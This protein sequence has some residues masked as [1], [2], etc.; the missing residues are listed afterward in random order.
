MRNNH[1]IKEYKTLCQKKKKEKKEIL[2]SIIY[3][4]FILELY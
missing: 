3:N 1:T 4:S 2:S